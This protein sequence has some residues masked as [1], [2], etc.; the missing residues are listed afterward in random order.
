MYIVIELFNYEYPAI[1]TDKEGKPLRFEHYSDALLEA[2]D[3]Q[4][5]LVVR[6]L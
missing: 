3:C 5:G 6:L 4:T 1:V 2:E